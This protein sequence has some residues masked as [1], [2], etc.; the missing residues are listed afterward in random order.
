MI[1]CVRIPNF[2][3]AVEQYEHEHLAATPFALIEVEKAVQVVYALS[4]AAISEGVRTGMTL[5]QA[6]TTCPAL[7]MLPANPAR[8]HRIASDISE[9]LAAF[10]PLVEQ[11]VTP[12]RIARG[13]YR[14]Q[15]SIRDDEG[16]A[17]WFL[18]PGRM[19]R[20]QGSDFAKKIHTS[21]F[22]AAHLF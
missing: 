20:T 11:E 15:P 6:Q 16:A 18:N 12:A 5:R 9:T 10:T 1:V 2:A 4:G 7:Q 22:E 13:R 8:Y 21:L 14:P 3:A 19:T 17:I